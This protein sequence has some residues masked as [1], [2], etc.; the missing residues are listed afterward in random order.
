MLAL[1]ESFGIGIGDEVLVQ[2][3]TCVAVPNSIL[4][5]GATPVY[6]DIDKT[7]NMDPGKL[8]DLLK[9]RYALCS[10]RPANRL[11]AI[12]PVHLYGQPADMDPIL[13]VAKKYGLRV[14]EDAA[15]AHGALYKGKP[16]GSVGDMACFSFYPGKNLGAYG[17][18]GP[19]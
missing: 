5:A 7:Y 9:K 17:D 3:F 11:K 18:G 6:V 1:L 4:W 8:E 16:V 19:L 2:A 13:S 15:Q 10:M 12:I 14:V